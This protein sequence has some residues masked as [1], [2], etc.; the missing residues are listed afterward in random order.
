MRRSTI[1]IGALVVSLVVIAGTYFY[2][3]Y[4]GDKETVESETRPVIAP[5]FS[6]P[7]ASGKTISL[8]SLEGKVKILNFWASWSPY[9]KEELDSLNRIQKEFGSEVV[10]VALSR[11]QYP[12]LGQEY[13]K[14]NSIE[15]SIVFIFDKED[16]Y[17]KKIEGFAVPET[18]FLN[19]N[20][21]IVLHKHGPITYEEVR[22]QVENMLY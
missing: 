7:D 21:E 13:L 16:D 1:I 10:V 3:K 4:S 12:S 15:Q 20:D 5:E 14:E 17:F 9:S 22:E 6:F 18:V 2:A 8:E 19:E 11:D